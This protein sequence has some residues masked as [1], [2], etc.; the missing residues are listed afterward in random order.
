M[1]DSQH[2]TATVVLHSSKSEDD[3]SAARVMCYSPTAVRNTTTV[4]YGALTVDLYATTA[5]RQYDS[6]PSNTKLY[7]N[8][9][10]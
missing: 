5:T 8:T 4:I 7:Y 10:L 6:Y 1:D 2:S 3:V 9:I